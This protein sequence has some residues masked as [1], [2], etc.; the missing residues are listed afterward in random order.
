MIFDSSF[1]GPEGLGSDD[2]SYQG[3]RYSEVRDALFRNAYYLTWGSPGD[4]P[5]PVY[6]VTLCRTLRGSL[7]G[8]PWRFFAA[9]RRTLD[10]E[11]DL[12]WGPDRRGFRRILHPNGVCL[13]GKWII[14]QAPE[15]R[16]YS[17]HFQKGTEALIIGR[18]SSCCTETRR[19][20]Y[21]SLSLVGKIYPTTD[22]NHTSPLRTANFITQE[23]LGGSKSMSLKE[24]ELRNAPDTTPWRRGPALPVLLVTG[25]VFSRNDKQKDIRQLYPI[26]ELG[27]P[28][29][30][31]TMAP[32]FMRLRIEKEPR[33]V[34]GDELDFRDEVL[35]QIY[36]RGDATP[37]RPLTFTIEVS[38]M[39]VTKGI[40]RRRRLI[41][42]WQ[43]IGRIEFTEGVASYN[44][45]F[46]LHFHHPPARRDRND[47]STLAWTRR[48]LR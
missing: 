13:M 33:H 39:G 9:T 24:V 18:Y 27:K 10:S 34:Y 46:V 47:P 29:N 38:D 5:L 19:G 25:F 6:G 35:G 14:D 32:E 22:P 21:R 1:F 43:R 42:N 45:D 40:L 44:G 4:P 2:E 11:A 30:T 37:K 36:D 28:E 12:R 8:S 23:D 26:A 16:N 3:S 17:G 41:E 20:H 7:F 15:G 31:P 48:G